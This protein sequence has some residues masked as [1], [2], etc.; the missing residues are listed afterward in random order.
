MGRTTTWTGIDG[1]AALLQAVL[2][3]RN[4]DAERVDA[5]NNIPYWRR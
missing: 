2:A 5:P 1:T 3:D 4:L